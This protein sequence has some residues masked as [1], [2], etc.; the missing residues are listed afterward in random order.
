[1][2]FKTNLCKIPG[3]SF[4]VSEFLLPSGFLRTCKLM[5]EITSDG[6]VLDVR[7][8]FRTYAKFSEKLTFLT[9]LG[10]RNVSFSEDF[11]YLPNK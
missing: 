2:L 1:M 7:H 8:S 4:L 9:Y 11:E 10:V 6:N 3:K 5:L